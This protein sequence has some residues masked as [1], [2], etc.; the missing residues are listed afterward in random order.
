MLRQHLT[1][2]PAVTVIDDV[3]WH[4]VEFVT[5]AVIV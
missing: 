5:V 3:D 4:P 2:L 1:A